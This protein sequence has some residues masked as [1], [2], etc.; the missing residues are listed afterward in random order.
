ME[1]K[2]RLWGKKSYNF[3][4]EVLVEL[5][6]EKSFRMINWDWKEKEESKSGIKVSDRYGGLTR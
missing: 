1:F 5:W 6:S 4:T 2:P 3:G